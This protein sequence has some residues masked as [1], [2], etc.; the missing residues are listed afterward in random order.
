MS[1]ITDALAKAHHARQDLLARRSDLAIGGGQEESMSASLSQL[2][3]ARG[4]F[5]NGSNQTHARR[6]VAQQEGDRLVLA[7]QQL[8]HQTSANE[9]TIRRLLMSRERLEQDIW[10]Y[11]QQGRALR[12]A[13]ETVQFQFA[14]WLALTG[15]MPS[16]KPSHGQHK[17]C[18]TNE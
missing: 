10:I 14:Q 5:V 9:A 11:Q 17:E 16:M 3:N 6:A 1:R 13:H 15:A 2:A 4:V 7:C 8:E 18:H 12:Q